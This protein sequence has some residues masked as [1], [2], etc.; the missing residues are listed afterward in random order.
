MVVRRSRL[1][2]GPRLLYVSNN[3]EDE[4]D[5]NND[6]NI[7]QIIP[8][9]SKTSTLFFAHN[10]FIQRCG[11]VMA[12]DDNADDGRRRPGDPCPWNCRQVRNTL[13]CC[14]IVTSQPTKDAAGPVLRLVLFFRRRRCCCRILVL[15]LF[16][17]LSLSL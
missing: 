4:D 13:D 11:M 3:E 6:N 15:L 5:V 2:R 7:L 10:T 12:D 16:L 14:R 9:H 1:R 8:K 17:L